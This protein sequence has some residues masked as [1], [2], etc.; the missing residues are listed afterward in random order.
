MLFGSLIT[1]QSFYQLTLLLYE[2]HSQDGSTRL[3]Q[4]RFILNANWNWNSLHRGW[5]KE[6]RREIM[7]EKTEREK[8]GW[9]ER[10]NK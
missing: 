9:E 1:L 6:E 3:E 10:E 7:E 5:K 2:P 8:V 4:V